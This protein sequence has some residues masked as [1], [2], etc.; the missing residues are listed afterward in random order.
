MVSSKD[1]DP[2]RLRDLLRTVEGKVPTQRLM[3]GLNYLEEPG[4][5]Q[6]ELAGRYGLSEGTVNNWLARLERLDSDDPEEVLGNR[7]PPGKPRAISS[8]EFDR[9]A[10][11][12]DASPREAGYDVDEW[13]TALVRRY[14]A[15]EFDVEY[16][17]RHVRRLIREA[18]A[19]RSPEGPGGGQ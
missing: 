19:A 18:R 4:V 8:A 9:L 15:E 2:D 3:L 10:T 1:V 16:S 5:T 11:A 6:A 14:T 12:I 13:T 7:S 17:S